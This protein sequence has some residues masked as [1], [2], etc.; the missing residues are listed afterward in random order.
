[1]MNFWIR[2]ALAWS[3][4][5]IT[6][7][8]T[9]SGAAEV[10]EV[11]VGKHAAFTRVVFE[12]DA[13]AGYR[14]ERRSDG[15]GESTSIL[16]TMEA[17]S[18]AYTI[19]RRAGMVE[20]VTVEEQL[21][22]AVARIRLRKPRLRLK[23]MILANPPRIVLDLMHEQPTSALATPKVRKVAVKTPAPSPK[24]T[25]PTPL[26]KRTTPARKP[27]ESKPAPRVSRPEP[28]APATA[29]VARTS[30]VAPIPRLKP[31][32]PE[33]TETEP[34]EGAVAVLRPSPTKKPSAAP[35]SA[36][37][38]SPPK[39][40]TPDPSVAQTP[41]DDIGGLSPV[42]IG[43]GVGGALLAVAGFVLFRRRR[44]ARRDA[45]ADDN[46]LFPSDRESESG[47]TVGGT[48]AGNDTMAVPAFGDPGEGGL[49]GNL[50]PA[51]APNPSSQSTP[52]AGPG[53]GLFGEDEKEE[54]TV[55][56]MST[57]MSGMDASA[58][59]AMPPAGDL[60]RVVA[61]LERRLNQA[62]TRLDESVEACERLERQMAAQSEELRVQ[63][64]AIART[65]RALR[66]LSRTD[67]EQAT[68]PAIRE[69]R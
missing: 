22:R 9:S 50:D 45:Y 49:F 38:T 47:F 25:P 1:M 61:E 3:V 10:T 18:R 40:I 37:R 13:P 39:S 62:E 63:R 64:A 33:P 53:S 44:A 68:E 30:N 42:M 6:A 2:P 46:D 48:E 15:S 57:P 31:I 67:E 35:K 66:S 60:L 16:V 11:R 7:F 12:L 14:I 43:A 4:L 23:E 41:G 54:S 5:W 28:V 36:T 21:G 27:F 32:V 55:D 51:T 65:Q 8:A 69:P 19:S 34:K 17:N 24:Q 58:P 52:M 29:E 59:G 26:P 20:S 56:Q